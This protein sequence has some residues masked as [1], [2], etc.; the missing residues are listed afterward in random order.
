MHR[1]RKMKAA[2]RSIDMIQRHVKIQEAFVLVFCLTCRRNVV[3][4][5][6]WPWH[7]RVLQDPE[8]RVLLPAFLCSPSLRPK[9][10]IVPS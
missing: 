4:E 10:L 5:D 3:S 2:W 6:H 1:R 8:W 7:T 9:G